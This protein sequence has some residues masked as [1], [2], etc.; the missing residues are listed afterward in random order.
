MKAKMTIAR[1]AT[2]SAQLQKGAPYD[3]QKENT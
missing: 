2:A 1:I 3:L